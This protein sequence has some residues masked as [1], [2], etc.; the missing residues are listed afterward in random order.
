MPDQKEAYFLKGGRL[1][2]FYAMRARRRPSGQHQRCSCS[3]AIERGGR[4]NTTI[5]N[6]ELQGLFVYDMKN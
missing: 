2:F 5:E 1:L 3:E 6:M 4:L